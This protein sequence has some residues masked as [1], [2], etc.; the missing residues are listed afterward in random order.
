MEPARP[1]CTTSTGPP[2]RSALAAPPR[3][4]ALAVPPPR[5][6]ALALLPWSRQEMRSSAGDG[7]ARPQ[8]Q[9]VSAPT[10]SAGC[11]TREGGEA[12]PRERVGGRSGEGEGGRSGEGEAPPREG[13]GAGHRRR[14]SGRGG[15]R[16]VLGWG[17]GRGTGE[18][19]GG[20]YLMRFFCL[21][22]VR[23]G[24]S[25]KFP[26]KRLFICL[27]SVLDLSTR[28]SFFPFFSSSSFQKNDF[29]F[30]PS[31]FFTLGKPHFCQVFFYTR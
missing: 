8:P 21:P 6:S 30:L 13:V 4:S 24:H 9:L 28:Q 2:R 10:G 11:V 18:G 25:A 14:R 12:P 7:R 3:R 22:S 29:I 1:T 31:V 20:G 17:L 26:E 27:P 19:T 23:S 15:A 5:R 16:G